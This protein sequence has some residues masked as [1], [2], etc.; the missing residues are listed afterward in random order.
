[1]KR[2][3]SSKSKQAVRIARAPITR[4][5]R[6]SLLQS[7]VSSGCGK[8]PVTANTVQLY[9][10]QIVLRRSHT[11]HTACVCVCVQLWLDNIECSAAYVALYELY[12]LRDGVSRAYT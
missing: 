5:G 9:E 7:Q 6:A 1:M 2:S 10:L 4:S 11:I 12:S 3:E 8:W